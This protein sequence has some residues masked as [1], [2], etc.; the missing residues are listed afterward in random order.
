MFRTWV[1][2]AMVDAVEGQVIDGSGCCQYDVT[3]FD[4]DERP[5]CVSVPLRS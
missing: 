3:S 2:E 1:A 5:C 4:D